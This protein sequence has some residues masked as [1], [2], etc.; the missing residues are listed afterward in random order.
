VRTA[1]GSASRSAA[2]AG[3]REH[4]ALETRRLTASPP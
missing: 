4:P 1:A 2:P 3:P